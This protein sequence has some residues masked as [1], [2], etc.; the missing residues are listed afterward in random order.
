ME[1]IEDHLKR[2]EREQQ[3]DGIRKEGLV[4]PEVLKQVIENCFDR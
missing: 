2:S 1:M 4:G 3:R